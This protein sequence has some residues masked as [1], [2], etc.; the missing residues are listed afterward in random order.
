MVFPALIPGRQ[1]LYRVL[2]QSMVGYV[3]SN[4]GWVGEDKGICKISTEK[5]KQKKINLNACF[6]ERA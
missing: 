6:L 4:L 3:S 1:G 2:I 5:G